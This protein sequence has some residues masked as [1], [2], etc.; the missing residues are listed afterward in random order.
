M[1]LTLKLGGLLGGTAIAL[2]WFPQADAN[3]A[4]S[5]VTYSPT[6]ENILNPERG[7][8]D[9]IDLINQ[10]DFSYIRSKGYTLVRAYVRLDNYRQ[11]PLPASFLQ[12][13]RQGFQRVRGS[14]IKVVLRFSYN[15]PEDTIPP[16]GAPDARIDRVLQHINQLKPILV[17]NADAIAVLQ[18]GFAGAWGEWHS[19]ANNLDSLQNRDRIAKALLAALPSSRAIQLRTPGYIGDIFP[20]PLTERYAFNGSYISR[21]GHHNDCFLSNQSDSGTYPPDPRE[22]KAYLAQISRWTPVGGETCQI[23]PREHRSDC[24]TAQKD[25]AQFHW[26]YLNS[27]FYLPDLNRWKR[28][29]CYNAIA[30]KLGYRLQLISSTLPTEVRSGSEYKGSFTI[31]NLGYASPFNRRNLQVVLRHQVTGKQY[32]LSILQSFSKT[33]DPRFWL[34]GAGKIKVNL[35]GGIPANAPPGIYQVLVN[36]PDPM[37]K[38]ANNPLYSIRLAN[39]NTWEAQTGYNSLLRTVKIDSGVPGFP[40]TGTIWFR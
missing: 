39:R 36:L 38:L 37:P 6:S 10:T 40:Y 29:G 24:V 23:T 15:F 13:L 2:A 9:E 19:S 30:N 11:Q 3:S 4:T 22:I 21:I 18:A 26:S 35:A 5:T 12:K 28:E 14:G 34:P 31:Q 1:K 16:G 20:Q 32:R 33:N 7:F 8:H 27:N 17:E 25:L